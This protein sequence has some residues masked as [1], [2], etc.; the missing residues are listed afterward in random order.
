MK[1]KKA[2]SLQGLLY[3][4]NEE[5]PEVLSQIIEYLDCFEGMESLAKKIIKCEAMSPEMLKLNLSSEERKT[6]LIEAR[7][8]V[9]YQEEALR[10]AEES[11]DKLCQ[12]EPRLRYSPT[13]RSIFKVRILNDLPL[14]D[15]ASIINIVDFEINTICDIFGINKGSRIENIFNSFVKALPAFAFYTK[16]ISKS[17]IKN[18]EGLCD[19]F[20]PEV[21]LTLVMCENEDQFE[22][23]EMIALKHAGMNISKNDIHEVHKRVGYI[24]LTKVRIKEEE[25]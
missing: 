8:F 21:G 11:L 6:L 13:L 18:M 7:D 5:E 9:N 1:E 15:I 22:E 24:P 25:K 16:G 23:L 19:M 2:K 3:I 14:P 10:K 12:K 17:E 20:R 4:L